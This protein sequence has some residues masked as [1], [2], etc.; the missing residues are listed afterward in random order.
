M[1]AM[2]RTCAEEPG[3]DALFHPITAAWFRDRF[4]APTEPQRLG[5]PAIASGEHTLIAA[6]TGSGKTLAAFLHCIDRLLRLGLEGTLRDQVDTVYVSP[7]KALSNDIQRNLEAPLAEVQARA[8]AAGFAAPEIR[9]LVRTGDTPP[10]A[11][12]AMARRPP[13]ILVT[14]PESLYLLLTSPKSREILRSVRTVI[15]DEIHALARD[16]RGSHLSLSLERLD[17]LAGRPAVRVGLSATQRPIDAIAAFLV[18]AKSADEA[19]RPCC[20]VIDSGHIRELELEVVVPASPLSA[21]CSHETWGEVYALLASTIRGGRST[22][23]FVNTRR[24]AERVAHALREE[25]GDH[26]VAS[27]HGSLSKSIRQDAEQRLKDGELKAVVATASLELGIDI[28]FVD[29]VCQIGSPRSI[30][31]FLQRVGRSGHSLGATPRGRLYPLTRDELLECMALVRAVRAGRLDAIEIPRG[32]LDILAQQLV[33][34]VACEDWDERA[35]FDLCRS[36]WPYRELSARDFEAVLEVVSEGIAPGKTRQGA[37]I[38][39]DRIHGR[40]RARKQARV[41][42]ATSGGAIPETADYRVVTADDHTYVGTV[43]EDFAIESLSGD[44]FLLGNTSWRIRYV[45]GGEVVVDDAHGAPASVPFWLGEAPARTRELSAEV[46]ALREDLAARVA[47]AGAESPE[48][49][50][51]L[52]RA[53]GASEHGAR[54]ALAYVEAQVAA[55]GTV[56]TQR[57]IVFER[58]FD[59]SGGMQLVVHSPY[60]ARINRAWGLAL[61]KRFCR[62]FNFELQASADDDGIVLSLGPQHSFPLDRMFHLVRRHHAREILVQAV[63]AAPFFSTRWRWNMNRSLAVLRQ[64]GGKRVPP[65]LQRMQADDLLAAVFPMQTACLENITGDIEVPDHP[66]VRQTLDDCLHEAMDLDA[67]LDLL[68]ALESGEIEVLGFDSREPSPFSYELLNANPYAFLD[69]APLE[70]RRARAVATRRTLEAQELRELARL[71]PEAVRRVREEA[72]PTVRD[73][74]ELHDTLL[75]MVALPAGDAEPAWQS[76]FE[77]LVANGRAARVTR[78]GSTADEEEKI[79][80]IAAESWPLVHAALGEVAAHP[81]PSLP[82]AVRS[83]YEAHEARV[84]LVRGQLQYR[85]VETARELAVRVGL[86]FDSTEAALEALEGEGF[87]LRGRW[88]RSAAPS[89]GASASAS[90]A[91]EDDEWCERRL[92]ARIHRLTLERLRKKIEPATPAD[93]VRFLA[94][95]SHLHADHRLDSIEGLWAVVDQ[96]AGFEAP[97]GAWEKEILSLRVAGYDPAWLDE[98]VR[99]G[100]AAWGRLRG[101][102]QSAPTE[103]SDARGDGGA[104][105]GPSA[106]TRAVPISVFPRADL[107]WLAAGL[108]PPDTARLSSPARRTLDAL[109]AG[110]SLFFHDLQRRSGLLATQVESALGELAARGLVT[111]DSF[112][113]IRPFVGDDHERSRYARSR[114]RRRDEPAVGNRAGSVPRLGARARALERAGLTVA[115]GPRAARWSLLDTSGGPAPH[116]ERLEFWA[117]LLLRRYGV[118]FRDLLAR[119]ALAP[120][121]GELV[122]IYRRLEARGEIRGGRFVAGVGGEQFAL[123]ESVDLLRR[124]RDDAA[125]DWFVISAADPLNVTGVVLE[126]PRVPTLATNALA[127]RRGELAASLQGGEVTFHQAVTP[128]QELELARAL[129][130]SGETRMRQAQEHR[131][132]GVPLAVEVAPCRSEGN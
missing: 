66:L 59:D 86:P 51:S 116:E 130:K 61:R 97:A 125:D 7:L 9:A 6:P 26:S 44:I 109:A 85:A 23:V 80:W 4:G 126:G 52:C 72:W 57:R 108:L 38:H 84:T 49:I 58:F 120:R 119:E 55:L 78:S 92:L 34:A 87:A 132:N 110:G 32:P 28:G 15:V 1:A 65:P 96:L 67:W 29:L 18:S 36:A 54:Q 10:S 43:N 113:A 30:A 98:L 104:R 33:A 39:R 70:E 60:G 62:S 14:T 5:W 117:W 64:R 74:E 88:S 63:L 17:A 31:T 123:E 75:S 69:D 91:R 24:L 47:Q 12:Q 100:H 81:E 99:S 53:C 20:R 107:L 8:V 83:E 94:R 2:D 127:F 82:P 101:P 103:R 13:H 11:R 131:D 40:L 56:P 77:E 3:L 42:A 129:R 37:Y 115:S 90:A 73:A 46:S 19:G 106:L 22:L 93:F 21:V 102:A 89:S 124:V 45:R 50:A 114:R 68:E 121:W 112:A 111:A 105:R 118:V 95:H 48:A 41:A 27:H 76:W 122:R 35:L 16:K 79:L 25:L 71:D 128:Q